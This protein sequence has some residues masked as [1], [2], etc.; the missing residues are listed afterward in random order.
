MVIVL[1]FSFWMVSCHIKLFNPVGTYM[2]IRWILFHYWIEF[3]IIFTDTPL[4]ISKE[5]FLTIAFISLIFI[6]DI[7]F[8]FKAFL[9]YLCPLIFNPY[10]FRIFDFSEKVP[11]LWIM[12]NGVPVLLLVLCPKKLFECFFRTDL[13]G[14]L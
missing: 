2:S 5:S 11:V 6:Y 7:W 8:V 3:P 4:R 12:H 1:I 14:T 10:P 9:S 13:L